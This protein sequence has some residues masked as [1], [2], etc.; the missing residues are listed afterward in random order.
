MS[1][2]PE[3]EARCTETLRELHTYIDDQLAAEV[4]VLV[5]E[6]LLECVDCMQAFD[7]HA[8]LKIV[9][10]RKCRSDAPLPGS[11][12]ERIEACFGIDADELDLDADGGGTSDAAR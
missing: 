3:P 5:D 11:L 10:A 4:K 1:P 8:E 7:F 2:T 12:L 6:H 9:I